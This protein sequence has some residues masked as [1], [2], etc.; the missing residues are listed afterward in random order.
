MNLELSGIG[1]LRLCPESMGRKLLRLLE[2]LVG[3]GGTRRVSEAVVEV[4][5]IGTDGPDEGID[6]DPVGILKEDCCCSEGI[7]FCACERESG[8]KTSKDPVV[9]KRKSI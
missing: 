3:A 1:I 7:I 9:E 6:G 5:S 4:V 2:R 8:D